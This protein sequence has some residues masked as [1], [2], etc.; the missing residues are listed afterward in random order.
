MKFENFKEKS[1]TWRSIKQR[2]SFLKNYFS[3]TPFREYNALN[4]DVGASFYI[5][6]ENHLPTGTFKIRGG[7]TL[8]SELKKAGV[9]S[10]VTYSTGNHGLSI[11]YASRIFGISATI[12]LPNSANPA[13]AELISREG[14]NLVYKGNVFDETTEFAHIL[15]DKNNS[16]FI[17]PANEPLLLEGVGTGFKEMSDCVPD[18]DY[19]FIPL[20]AGSEVASAV[21]Y[22]KGR[23]LKTKI[24][25]VQAL[26]SCA[27]YLSWK[28][29]R[30]TSSSD[31]TFAGGL[32]TGNAYSLPFYIYKNS[33][34]DFI[35]LSEEELRIG[36]KLSWKYTHNLVEGAGG[37]ALAAA[38]KSRDQLKGK[39]VG[40]QMSGCNADIKNISRLFNA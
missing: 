19:I 33:L 23:G 22:F 36:I 4:R 11:A 28:N 12:V 39:K 7:I 37:A 5:K 31:S 9:R 8:L 13:K 10:V 14:A 15:A 34:Y 26:S 1:I 21:T 29:G 20:G 25:A 40:I 6:H 38:W 16:Y 27:A 35:L 18:L 2:H 3:P 24:I 17:H 32:A 30:M